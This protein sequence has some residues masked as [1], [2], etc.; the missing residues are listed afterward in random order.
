MTEGLIRRRLL[1]GYLS[2]KELAEQINRA[3]RT[4][5]EWRAKRIGPPFTRIGRAYFYPEEKFLKWLE[6]GTQTPVRA[7]RRGLGAQ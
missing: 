7:R 4:L 3:P 1:T 2:E 6:A 5:Q